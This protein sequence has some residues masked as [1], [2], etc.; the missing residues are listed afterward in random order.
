[1]LTVAWI[2]GVLRQA[3]TQTRKQTR[4]APEP[5]QVLVWIL[6]TTGLSV[7]FVQVVR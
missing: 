2:S 6:D 4:S 7:T 1:M 3:V 5:R